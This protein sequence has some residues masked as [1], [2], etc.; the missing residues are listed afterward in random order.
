[1]FFTTRRS[2]DSNRRRRRMGGDTPSARSTREGMSPKSATLGA[3]QAATRPEGR[4]RDR[5]SLIGRIPPSPP[6]LCNRSPAR[7]GA[8]QKRGGT[9]KNEEPFPVARRTTR[10]R[11]C[12]NVLQEEGAAAGHATEAGGDARSVRRTARPDG[13]R[14]V[15]ED[16]RAR[17][18]QEGLDGREDRGGVQGEESEET[19]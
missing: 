14:A 11:P 10:V 8:G 18:R 6:S 3:R 4:W 5:L 19:V 7:R 16:R 9:K 1:M 17:G 13:R 15:K 12:G 2:G